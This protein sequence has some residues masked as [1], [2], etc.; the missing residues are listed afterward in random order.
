MTTV[1]IQLQLRIYKKMK[2]HIPP[3]SSRTVVS[4]HQWEGGHEHRNTPRHHMVRSEKHMQMLGI[5]IYISHN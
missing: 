3:G 4:S 5:L 1:V 2:G